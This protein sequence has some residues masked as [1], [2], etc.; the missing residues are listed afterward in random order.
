MQP[1][2]TFTARYLADGSTAFRCRQTGERYIVGQIPHG[3]CYAYRNGEL[4][5]ASGNR[6]TVINAIESDARWAIRRAN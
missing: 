4:M 6:A 2:P 3:H 1:Q 5:I